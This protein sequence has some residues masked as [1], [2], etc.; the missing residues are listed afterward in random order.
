M[1]WISV[2]EKPKLIMFE[3]R[4]SEDLLLW[5][6]GYKSQVIG[7]YNDRDEWRVYTDAE[8]VCEHITHWMPL[9]CP[10]KES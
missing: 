7:Y 6:Y 8:N 10:P 9:P 2:D 3:N 1:T 4:F 5:H